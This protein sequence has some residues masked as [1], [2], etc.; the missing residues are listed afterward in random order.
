MGRM[1][2]QEKDAFR[3]ESGDSYN[4]VFGPGIRRIRSKTRRAN[5]AILSVSLAQGQSSLSHDGTKTWLNR[6]RACTFPDE[7]SH[8]RALFERPFFHCKT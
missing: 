7:T 3:R 6:V 1:Q 2:G 8:D 4:V 5:R